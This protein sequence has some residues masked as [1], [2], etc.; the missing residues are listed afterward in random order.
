MTKITDLAIR[1]FPVP[2]R[3][4]KAYWDDSLPGFAVRVSQGGRKSF[5]VMFGGAQN[6]R[7]K[8]I[9]RFPETTLS[10]ARKAAKRL[11]ANQSS[12]KSATAYS[13]AREDFLE[14]CA[15][16]N[17]PNTVREYARYL[18]A[19]EY[20][21]KIE[22][23]SRRNIQDHLKIYNQHP[24]S[25]AHALTAFKVFFNWAIRHELIDRHPLAGERAVSSP[26]R[27]RVLTTEELK[28]IWHYEYPPFSN[29]LKLLILTCRPISSP[30]P[31]RC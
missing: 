21:R 6:R 18:N 25:Y 29:I 27:N 1:K 11:L 26:P 10:E 8:T 9:G 24:S 14:E 20:A 3:G 16:K 30:M 15:S 7:L 4:Q 5:V 28:A 22:D 2:Q 31:T 12:Y 13:D 19:Y 23:I 17:R